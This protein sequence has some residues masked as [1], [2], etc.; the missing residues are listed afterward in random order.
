MKPMQRT[1]AAALAA[2]GLAGP[3]P[4]SEI[5]ASMQ[6]E[7]TRQAESIKALAANPAV[8]KA[9]LDQNQKGP[10]EGMTNEKWKAVRRSDDLVRDF[11]KN[12]AGKVLVQKV[13]ASDGFWVRAFLSAAGGEKVAF[14]E[15]TISYLHA[16][17]PK[18]DVPFS[19]GKVWQG[20]P[21]LDT[22][23]ETNDVQVAAPVMS[24]GKSVGV[25]IVGVNLSRLSKSTAK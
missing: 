13:E 21:E 18:F 9:V 22:V 23:T 15:K 12:D 19:T 1:F 10:I 4:A 8:V 5:T 6:K 24:G 17:Q 14:T 7:L 3:A 20:P 2:L 25:L 16:G 11:V